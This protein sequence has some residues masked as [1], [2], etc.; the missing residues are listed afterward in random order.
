MMTPATTDPAPKPSA[1][2][3]SRRGVSTRSILPSIAV[4]SLPADV[5]IVDHV[6]RFHVNLNATETFPDGKRR[7]QRLLDLA[8]GIGGA[9][10]GLVV[11]L[12]EVFD[13]REGF[14]EHLGVLKPST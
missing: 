9:E 7:T 1:V 14:G 11:G 5:A 12:I 8:G 10:E 13:A 3:I 2:E 6:F 4:M